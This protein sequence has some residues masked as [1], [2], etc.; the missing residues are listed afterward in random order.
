MKIFDFPRLPVKTQLFHVPGAA[1]DGGYTSGGA[2]IMSPEPGGRSILELQLSLH[3]NEWGNPALSWLMSKINGE[4]FR[5]MLTNTP[6]IL[7]QYT[8][9]NSGVLYK[10][11][12]WALE[13]V[14]PKGP[15]DN[16]KNW[17]ADGETLNVITASLVGT[18]S[19][20]VD[21]GS[22]TDKLRRGH[23]IGFYDSCYMIDEIVEGDNNAAILTVKPPL[24]NTLIVN[25][26]AYL[27]PY[28]IG[29][30]ANAEEFRQ[31]YDIIN[32]GHLQPGRLIFK[33]AIVS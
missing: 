3:T 8:Q 26:T 22:Y 21:L 4:I 29:T 7:S 16:G 13:G 30:I 14:Y 25:D 31:S 27:R 17:L 24:R 2:R 10:T 19:V 6:Q 32:V 12:P 9:G 20:T 15:W 18:T 33:E 11:V 1:I 5:V 28:F 23:V